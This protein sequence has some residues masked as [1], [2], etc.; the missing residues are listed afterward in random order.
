MQHT[1]ICSVGIDIGTSTTQL[2]FSRLSIRNTAG[3]FTVPH[4]EITDKQV[5]FRSPVFDTP[6]LDTSH[7]DGDALR[8]L[9]E[10]IYAEAGVLPAQVQT[11]A[12]VITG[13][14]AR[15]ENARIVLAQISAF[16]GDFVV[17]TAGPDLESVLA[18]Q[19]SG[20]QQYSRDHNTVVANL[21]IGG[22]TTNIAVFDCG[23]VIANGCLDI[24]GRQI[25]LAP[26]GAIQA[27]YSGAQKTAAACHIALCPGQTAA[28][29]VLEQLC[30]KMNE[31]LEQLFGLSPVSALANQLK[32]PGS[33]PFVLPS[34]CLIRFLSFSGGVADCIMQPPPEPFAYHDI[35]V[36]LGRAI[37]RGRLLGHFRILPARETIRATVVGAGTYTTRLSG[38]TIAYDSGLFP[39]KNIPV[40]RLST[41]EECRVLAGDDALLR[42]RVLWF[43]QQSDSRM[44]LLAMEGPVDPTY[45]QLCRLADCLL[46]GL[47]NALPD[48]APLL[49]LTHRD[50]AKALG[51]LLRRQAGS[52]PVIAVDGIDIGNGQFIDLGAPVLNGMAIPVIVKTLVF[53]S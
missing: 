5:F 48:S 42:E 16:A 4:A 37:R 53:E 32:T 38:S 24:G 51:Q 21:D 33:T 6:L 19:G 1:E 13:E 18:G 29:D 17:S 31:V 46:S 8:A 49:V 44:L 11:G 40:L 34:N 23:R 28:Q 7:I 14:T 2:I 39:L 50:I 47:G 43:L 26:D 27:I 36:L 20:A 45:S 25:S 22:G 3:Y 9:I 12:V 41:E 52:R 30:S 15:R 10:H 35:G